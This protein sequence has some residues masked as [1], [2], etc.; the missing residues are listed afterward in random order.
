MV[1]TTW[2]EWADRPGLC[3][4]GAPESQLD[5]CATSA[6]TTCSS[7][8]T[9]AIETLDQHHDGDIRRELLQRHLRRKFR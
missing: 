4:P 7:G 3:R 6:A 8:A 9:A 2:S 1:W 5:A